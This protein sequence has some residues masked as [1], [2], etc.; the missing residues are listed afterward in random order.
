M[1]GYLARRLVDAALTIVLVLTLVFLA[2]RVLPGD[3]AVSALGEDATP[4]QLA[5]FRA[6]MGLD[7]PLPAQY[8]TFLWQMARFQ[9]GRSFVSDETTRSMLATALPYTIEL[10]L[11]AILVG[12]AIGIPAGVLSATRRGRAADYA[13]RGLSLLGFCIP[14]FY[15]AALMLIGFALKLDLFPIMGGGDALP[16]RLYHL[17][18]PALTLGLVMA[19]FTCRLTRSSMLEVLPRQF[20]RTARAKGASPA[21]VVMHHALRNA[22]IPVSTGFG[23]YI[24]TMLSGSIPV[25]LVFS[26]PGLGTV[27]V[28]AILARDYPVVQ[29]CLALFTLFVVVVNLAMDVVYALVDPRIRV[30]GV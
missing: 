6:R 4:D 30:A 12:A 5:A 19:A 3:P 25:E 13:A 28:N 21:R 1:S 2:M 15:L 8:L 11:A 16:D 10:T 20:V 9:F 17:V 7:V 27:L 14:E 22:L 18:L 26:R 24:L 29:G 23:I